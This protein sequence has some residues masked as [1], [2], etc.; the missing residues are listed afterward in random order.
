MRKGQLWVF[1]FGDLPAFCPVDPALS[2][3][4]LPLELCLL[5]PIQPDADTTTSEDDTGV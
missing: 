2:G 1:T 5:L 4:L 3:A